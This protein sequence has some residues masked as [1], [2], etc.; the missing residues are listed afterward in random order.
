[1]Q[2]EPS[3]PTKLILDHSDEFQ[4]VGWAASEVRSTSPDDPDV[5]SAYKSAVVATGIRHSDKQSLTLRGKK[6]DALLSVVKQW[7]EAGPP[8]EDDPVTYP[9]RAKSYRTACVIVARTVGLSA[10]I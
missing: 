4:A 1:M 9:A 3:N 2:Y 6:A 5:K 7:V 8:E 10:E